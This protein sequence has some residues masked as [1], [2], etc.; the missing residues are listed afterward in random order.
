VD[1]RRRDAYARKLRGQRH[2]EA[3]GVGC[4]NQLFRVGGRLAFFKSG[5]E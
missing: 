5:L 2:R 3:P 1:A 4:A